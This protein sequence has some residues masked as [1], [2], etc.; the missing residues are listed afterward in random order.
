MSQIKVIEF[1]TNNPAH[2]QAFK[3]I[4]YAWINKYFKVEQ[5]D[6]DS[7]ENPTKY[8]LDTGGAILL[9]CSG[10]EFLGATALKPIGNNSLELCKMGVSEAA[11]GLGVGYA[12]GIAAVTKAKE[13]GFERLYLETNSGLSPALNLYKKLGFNYVQNFTSPYQRADVAMEMYL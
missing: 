9:A 7:L 8:F 3:D 2:Y 5:G 6:L 1:D 13:L 4:N 12:I 10:D 11:R